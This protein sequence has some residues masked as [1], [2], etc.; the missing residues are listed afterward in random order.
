MN[1]KK[2]LDFTRK[3]RLAT[4]PTSVSKPER[5]SR[6]PD[7]GLSALKSGLKFGFRIFKKI[8]LNFRVMI[9]KVLNIIDRIV[10]TYT[11]EDFS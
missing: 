5:F 10:Q 4:V 2:P 3:I 1:V 6:N 11:Y 7:F 9:V 8:F